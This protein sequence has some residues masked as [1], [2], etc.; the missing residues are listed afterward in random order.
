MVQSTVAMRHKPLIS[1]T[2]DNIT[3]KAAFSASLAHRKESAM[4]AS[5]EDDPDTI[6]PGWIIPRLW[7]RAT[8]LLERPPLDH[9]CSSC[10]GPCGSYWQE[11]D[12]RQHGWRCATCCPPARGDDQIVYADQ[13]EEPR[14]RA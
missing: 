2:R 3:I 13:V 7:P 8:P 5:L 4:S 6:T 12:G 9:T 14:R 10:G 1:L 11:R